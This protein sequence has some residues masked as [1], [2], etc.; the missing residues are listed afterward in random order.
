MLKFVSVLAMVFT[1]PVPGE[2]FADMQI[3]HRPV[4][5]SEDQLT[6]VRV[7]LEHEKVPRVVAHF[8]G[9]ATGERA[10]IDPGNGRIREGVPYYDGLI[11]HRLIHNFVIQGGDPLG[12]GSGGPGYVVQDQFD[13]SLRHSGRYFLSCAKTTNPNTFG[14]QFFITL[15]ATPHLDD[16]HSIF[17]EVVNVSAEDTSSRDFIDGLTSVTEYPTAGSDKPVNPIT[18]ESVSFSGDDYADFD[19]NDPSYRLPYVVGI[20]SRINYSAEDGMTAFIDRKTSFNYRTYISTDLESWSS[21]RNL[22]SVDEEDDYEFVITGVPGKFFYREVGVDYSQVYNPT[23]E[24]FSK[25]SSLKFQSAA[26][27]GILS[28]HTELNGGFEGTVGGAATST[29]NRPFIFTPAP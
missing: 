17:G 2:I 5:S 14:S 10:W 16:K 19:V 18:I 21:F 23:E 22:L 7:R 4:S 12:L 15:A 13:Q 9:L 6:T 26:L 3:R 8:I 11:F 1:L 28:F 25:G 29:F 27:N 20:D 24:M